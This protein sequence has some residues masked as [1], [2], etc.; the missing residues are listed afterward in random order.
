[1]LDSSPTRLTKQT[2][3]YGSCNRDC[4]A[5]LRINT[6]NIKAY[7][8]SASACL[9]LDKL[10]A[11][12]DACERGLSLD[13][14]NAPLTTLSTKIQKRTSYVAELEQKRLAREARR[15]REAAT[16]KHALAARG[17]PTRT[18]TKAPEMEDAQ[19]TLEDPMNA[20]S[21]LS[22]P[23]ILLYPLHHQTDFIKSFPEDESVG[24]HLTYIFPLPWDEDNEYTPEGVECYIETVSGGLIKAGKK[25]ALLRILASGKVE[26]VDG[27]LRI[28][29]LPKTKA[30]KWIEEFKKVKPSSR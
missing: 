26:I 13:P 2:E 30:A 27:L 1:M 9:A 19:I 12:T 16:I 23:A 17:I 4:A 22:V 7:Y 11:A 3:N 20:A 10:T 25:L 18:T 24:Q 29:V 14:A 6:S 5:V 28:H 8:R 15:Q 21:T